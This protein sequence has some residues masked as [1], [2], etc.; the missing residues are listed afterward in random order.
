MQIWSGT[1]NTNKSLVNWFLERPWA[2]FRRCLGQ[3]EASLGRSWALLG[4]FGAVRNR[5][6]FFKQ[7]S[8]LVSKTPL[9]SILG[10]F[11]ESFGRFLGG[12]GETLGAPLGNYYLISCAYCVCLLLHHIFLQE[13]PRCLA[14]PR[15]ASQY[16]GVPQP[17]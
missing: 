15:R 10:G 13:P 6:F 4:C 17:P 3:P 14:T 11:V 12:F 8:K 2:P 1:I 9:G 7:W 16:A 5:V